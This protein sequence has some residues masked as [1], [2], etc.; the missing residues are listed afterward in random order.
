MSNFISFL[1][2]LNGLV[3]GWNLFGFVS[4]GSVLCGVAVLVG[5]LAAIP[6]ILASSRSESN[7]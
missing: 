2:V 1:F 4:F 6:A 3:M 7:A 5:A